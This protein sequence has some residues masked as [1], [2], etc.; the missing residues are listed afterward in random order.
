MYLVLGGD[1]SDSS[2]SAERWQL[3]VRLGL[4]F[5]GF[6]DHGDLPSNWTAEFA[7]TSDATGGWTTVTGWNA[8]GPL[9]WA[10]DTQSYMEDYAI[11]SAVALIGT[12]AVSSQVRLDS[13]KLSPINTSGHVEG[14]R[15]TLATADTPVPGTSGGGMLPLQNSCVV[16]TRTPVSG[17]TGR[18]RFYLPATAKDGLGD[19]GAFTSTYVG[20][21]KDAAQA[22]LEGLSYTDADPAGAHVRPIVTGGSYVHYGMITEIKVG[23]RPD[24]QRRRRRQLTETYVSQA[25]SYG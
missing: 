7:N 19:H 23:D 16:S 1:Y 14:G 4:V 17:R 5:G 22:F 15:V 18:G 13:V 3:G 2:D 11:P 21:V 9:S 10:L 6:D 8:N 24:T 12:D 20:V 25:L